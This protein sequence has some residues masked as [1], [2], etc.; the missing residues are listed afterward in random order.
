MKKIQKNAAISWI[1][2]K[3]YYKVGN[4][5]H[6]DGL[7]PKYYSTQYPL[8]HIGPAG[9]WLYQMLED[10]RDSVVHKDWTSGLKQNIYNACFYLSEV[11]PCRNGLQDNLQESGREIWS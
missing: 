2:T 10:V 5:N 3:K 7:C 6:I 11:T 9:L 1:P 8:Q 4:P